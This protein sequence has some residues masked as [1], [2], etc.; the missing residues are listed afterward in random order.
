MGAV[1]GGSRVGPWASGYDPAVERSSDGQAIQAT[2]RTARIFNQ[3]LGKLVHMR[4]A[5][6]A[7]GE[8][9]VHDRISL[10]FEAQGLM[11]S[12]RSGEALLLSREAQLAMRRQAQAAPAAAEPAPAA[13]P[14]AA[15]AAASEPATPTSS[16]APTD[17]TDQTGQSGQAAA[18]SPST[19]SSASARLDT[20][21]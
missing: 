18:D 10:E 13:T 16:P 7:N 17:S 9:V 20:R 15:P 14:T 5:A 12:A 19:D 6:A 11:L 3:E 2:S 8:V 1:S 4:H 21:A